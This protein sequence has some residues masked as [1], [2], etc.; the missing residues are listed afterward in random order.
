LGAINVF[1]SA[2]SSV[3]HGA[4]LS[5]KR[6]MTYGLYLRL[7]YTDAPAIDHGQDALV[8][9]RPATVQNTYSPSSERGNLVTDQRPLDV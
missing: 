9:G 6:Q 5:V 3:Y 8:A 1:E 7:G 4:T 2:A